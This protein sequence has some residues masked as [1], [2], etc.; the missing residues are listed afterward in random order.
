METSDQPSAVA[1]LPE[2]EAAEIV[3]AD[4]EAALVWARE[5]GLSDSARIKT[6]SPWLLASDDA[7]IEPLEARLSGEKRRKYLYSIEH[8][9]LQVHEAFKKSADTCDFSLVGAR[10][11]AAVQVIFR[12]AACLE[13]IDLSS[14]VVSL[15]V[16]TDDA[17]IETRLNPP[18]RQ[19]F[20]HTGK[21][22]EISTYIQMEEKSGM[23]PPRRGR[24]WG[25][26]G[27]EY[28]G[29]RLFEKFWSLT[30]RRAR[31]KTAFIGRECELLRETCF[32]LALRGWALEHL[33]VLQLE[34][35]EVPKPCIVAIEKNV[36]PVVESFTRTWLVDDLVENMTNLIIGRMIDMVGRQISS[37]DHW[38]KYLDSSNLGKRDVVLTNFPSAVEFIALSAECS[39]R[40]IPVV[41]FQHGAPPDIGGNLGE[42][43]AYREVNIADLHIGFSTES[44]KQPERFPLSKGIVKAVGLPRQY[45]RVG[46]KKRN[47][48]PMPPIVYVSTRLPRGNVNFLVTSQTD[49]ENACDECR[50]IEYVLAELPYKVLYK[51]YPGEIR[52]ADPDIATEC[53]VRQ[54][55]VEVLKEKIDMRYLLPDSRIIIAARATSTISWCVMSNKPFIFIELPN[56]TPLSKQATNEFG[57]A[58]FLFDA[59]S[60]TF[61]ADLRTFL[62]RPLPDIEKEWVTKS[63]YRETVI[64]KYFSV[65]VPNAGS[66]AAQTISEF[67]LRRD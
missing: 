40:N 16:S 24:R 34:P 57:N 46:W 18:W 32:F 17:G 62:S 19:I 11:A 14:N 8:F 50:L 45:Y 28:V 12:K 47:N 30:P 37:A 26:Q 58:F 53:A 4:S 55:N 63:R 49:Y 2:L 29:Y 1:T 23:P 44:E 35:A 25:L 67:S 54:K 65:A 41:S 21:L 60:P 51:P 64:K 27:W 52:Y 31:L 9:S 38:P 43:V 48:P 6:S 61:H 66:R 15:S 22:S 13:K 3:F 56:D 36:K 33:P 7:Q 5:R 20:G 39:K 10:E 42:F 59:S